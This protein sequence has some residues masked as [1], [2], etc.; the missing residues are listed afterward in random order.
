MKRI[1]LLLMIL[2]IVLCYLTSCESKDPVQQ[3]SSSI[4]MCTIKQGPNSW[5]IFDRPREVCMN[6]RGCY[7]EFKSLSS[8][9]LVRGNYSVECTGGN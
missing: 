2:V 7:L 5:T 4:V 3:E 8:S 6:D 1:Y 9:V